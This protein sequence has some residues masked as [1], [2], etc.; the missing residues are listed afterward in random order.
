VLINKKGIEL[1]LIRA[2][3]GEDKKNW[4]YRIFLSSYCGEGK[5][6]KYSGIKKYLD[7]SPQWKLTYEDD[8]SLMYVKK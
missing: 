1:I 7:D 6:T 8:A 4:F 2:T 5:N 3:G